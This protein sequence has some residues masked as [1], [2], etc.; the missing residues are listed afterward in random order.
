MRQSLD[1]FKDISVKQ[2][3]VGSLADLEALEQAVL[4]SAQASL[5]KFQ[6]LLARDGGLSA[7]AAL[8]F[9]DAGCDPLDSARPLN[10]VE[11][12]N[13]SFTYLASIAA[14]AWLF[15]HHPENAP[16]IL[17]LGTAAG[18]DIISQDR[19]IAAETFAATHPGSNRKLDKDVEKVRKIEATHRYVFSLSPVAARR[20]DFDGVKVVRL[21]HDSLR[22]IAREDV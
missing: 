17:N 18:S 20:V 21:S 5:Q 10:L 1:I 14:T 3:L 8:K 4:S 15:Q 19:E 22:A 2:R 6:E 12:L 16:F 11:Q 7:L 13:Q 9:S